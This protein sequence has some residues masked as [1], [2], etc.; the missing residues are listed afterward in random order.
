[1]EL[2]RAQLLKIF[3]ETGCFFGLVGY[4]TR[5][6]RRLAKPQAASILYTAHFRGGIV[7]SSADWE[8]LIPLAVAGDRPATER[9][10]VAH[11]AMLEGRIAA[12]LPHGLREVVAVEDLLQETI[13]QAIRCLP[14]CG[15]QSSQAFAAWL[16]AIADHQV[17]DVIRAATCH[18]RGGGWHQIANVNGGSADMAVMERLQDSALTPGSAAAC[19]EAVAAIKSALDELPSDEGRAMRLHVLDGK[20]LDETATAI[21]RSPGAVRGLIHRAKRRLRDLM[22]SSSRWFDSK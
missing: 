17:V 4:N 7:H 6:V 11:Y 8:R 13:V 21:N 15:A 18:K 14:K 12:R 19:I 22:H 9:L 20:S 1:V 5:H 2:R 16:K 10:L 3:E